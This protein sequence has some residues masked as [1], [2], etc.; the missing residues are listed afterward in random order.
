M[1]WSTGVDES[2]PRNNPQFLFNNIPI[3]NIYDYNRDGSVNSVDEVDRP[4][5]SDQSHARP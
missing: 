2:G 5:E 4:H 3:T 1:R